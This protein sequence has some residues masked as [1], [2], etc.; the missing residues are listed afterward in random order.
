MGFSSFSNLEEQRAQTLEIE[1]EKMIAK[2][3]YGAIDRAEE[4]CDSG[5][6]SGESEDEDVK[7]NEKEDETSNGNGMGSKDE[8][9]TAFIQQ[10]PV[11]TEND[12]EEQIKSVQAAEKEGALCINIL[13]LWYFNSYFLCAYRISS[14][15]N[16]A[17]QGYT[18]LISYK[19]II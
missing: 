3:K 1:L 7:E 8:E 18:N 5:V 10:E 17:K 15:S 14:V 2:E 12:L 4:E 19:N 9:E 6:S 13:F 16:F 11:K